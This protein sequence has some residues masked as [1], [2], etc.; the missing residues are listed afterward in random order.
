MQEPTPKIATLHG[1]DDLVVQ[2]PLLFVQQ[3][4]VLN[5]CEHHHS[6]KASRLASFG[7]ESGSICFSVPPLG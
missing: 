6:V 2:V 3:C 7:T 1:S 5:R 4:F